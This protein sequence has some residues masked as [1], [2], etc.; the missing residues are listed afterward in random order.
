M[1]ARQDVKERGI[2]EVGEIQEADA[3]KDRRRWP[4]RQIDRKA[5]MQIDAGA[6]LRD[7]VIA[8]ISTGG[9]KL[10]VEGFE[11][12]DEF[13]LMLSGDGIIKECYYQVVWRLG[14]EV[15]ARFVG[16]VR[17]ETA[18]SPQAM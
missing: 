18:Q 1:G 7:C 13:I 3:A 6:P 8:D 2:E 5:K 12:P 15:G 16:V 11:V 14:R 9:V 17:H 10:H 4:R